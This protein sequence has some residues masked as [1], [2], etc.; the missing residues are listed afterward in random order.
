M[1]QP[2]FGTTP[3]V[4]ITYLRPP[5]GPQ[6]PTVEFFRREKQ[7]EGGNSFTSNHYHA[8]GA[9]KCQALAVPTSSVDSIRHPNILVAIQAC[10]H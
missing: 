7:H 9:G 3:S 10:P 4:S 5:H 1:C 6:Q 2:Y 8:R